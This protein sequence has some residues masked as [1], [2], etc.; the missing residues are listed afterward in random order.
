MLQNKKIIQLAISAIMAL[1]FVNFYLKQKEQSIA[2]AY[3]MVEVLAASRDIPPNSLLTPEN[4]T[5][6][7][8][9]ERFMEPGAII[10]K[11]PAQAL[12]RVQGKITIAALPEGA[13]LMQSNM[14]EPSM[15]KTGVSPLLPPGKRGYLLRLGNLDVA[16]L[17]LPGDRIDIMATFSV[18]QN[19]SNSKATYT[20]L[21]N[22]L[23]LG[24]GKE[25]KK[26]KE[27]VSRK[28]ENE[29]GL[30]LTLAVDP[31]EAERLALAQNESQGEI[32]VIV[33]PHGDMEIKPLP[34]ITPNHLLG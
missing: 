21:Q 9:P 6:K 33:R 34:G 28:K 10:V 26:S 12:A 20:I 3:G 17:I 31:T 22:I 4:L 16:R 18:H 14:T 2:N 1:L 13:Q 7:Q 25:L 32:S 30:V 5:I 15:E 24:V 8:V 27:D 29:E 19:N 11:I 23:V